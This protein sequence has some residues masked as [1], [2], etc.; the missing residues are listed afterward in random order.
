MRRGASDVSGSSDAAADLFS[1]AL[2][3]SYVD[4][5]PRFLERSWLAD[6]IEEQLADSACRFLLLTGEPGSGKT[7]LL[8]WLARSNPAWPRYFIRRD[9]QVPLNSGDARSLLFAL[10]HQLAALRPDLFHPD[11]LELVVSQRVGEVAR[12]GRAVGISVEDL[13]VSPFYET[14][15]R[16][17][18]QA[19]FVAGELAGIS[20]GRLV[21]EERLLQVTNLQYLAVVDPAELLLRDD[22]EGRLV[23]LIDALDELR[24]QPGEESALDWLAACPELS[25]NVRF[26]LTSRPDERLLEVF[27][28]RQSEWLREAAMAADPYKVEADLGRYATSF[29]GEANVAAALAANDIAPDRFIAEMVARAEGNFLYL[30]ALFRALERAVAAVEA[31]EPGQRAEQEQLHRLL[32]LEEVPAGLSELYAFFL[33]L[34]R[35]A[36]ASERVEVAGAVLGESTYLPAWEGLYQPVLGVLAVARE[37]LTGKQIRRFGAIESEERWLE[38]ALG[39]LGPFLDRADGGYELYHATFAEFLT[40]AE[41]QRTHPRDYLNAVEWHRK[42]AAQALATQGEDWLSSE[43]DY[44]L[45]HTPSHLLEALT[46]P[47]SESS[48]E[49]LRHALIDVLTSFDFVEAK[50]RRLGIGPV[51]VDLRAALEVLE[52]PP[53][54]LAVALAVLDREAHNL[55]GWD[56]SRDPAVFA[57]QLLVRSD[58]HSEVFLRAAR[59]RLEALRVPY[60]A[61]RWRVGGESPALM[62]TLTG[63]E[64]DVSDV[65]VAADGHTLASAGH[66]GTVRVWDAES[67]RQLQ[68]LSANGAPIFAVAFA[69]NEYVLAASRD[70]GVWVFDLRSGLVERVFRRPVAHG[71]EAPSARALAASANGCVVAGYED[72]AVLVWSLHA[73]RLECILGAHGRQVNGAAFVDEN[74][75]ITCSDDGTVRVWDLRSGRLERILGEKYRDENFAVIDFRG[76]GYEEFPIFVEAVAAGPEGRVA[77]GLNDGTIFVWNLTAGTTERVYLGPASPVNSVAFAGDGRVIS[78]SDDRMIRLWG[79]S[80]TEPDRTFR[81]HDVWVNALMT[82]RGGRILSGSTDGTLKLWDLQV[83]ASKPAATGHRDWVRCVTVAANDLVVSG[84][85]DGTLRVWELTSGKPVRTIDA[86]DDWVLAVAVSPEGRIISG[87]RDWTVRTWDLASGRLEHTLTGHEGWVYAVAA[88]PGGRVVSGS[89]DGTVRIWNTGAG[90]LERVLNGHAGQVWAVAATADGCVVSASEGDNIRIWDLNSGDLVD[91][92]EGHDGRVGDVALLPPGRFASAGWDGTVRVWNLA[93]RR[94]ERTLRGHR[95][96]VTR[97]VALPPDRLL[98]TG[99]DRTLRVWDLDSGRLAAHVVLENVPACL[100]LAPAS[101]GVLIGDRLGGLSCL[102]LVSGSAEP[103]NE[104]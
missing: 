88:A 96:A 9:S 36:V 4:D 6:L 54:R 1:Q 56:P 61:P 17:E 48:Q 64:G 80:A 69:L 38:G 23:I 59:S 87:S 15:L 66:D 40:A 2:V 7:A 67:G 89:A 24:Y 12:G 53:V 37:P 70:G 47:A 42:I 93:D 82:L 32:R 44:P 18:Q 103:Q 86:H 74:T 50:C 49:P 60:F 30:A 94:L 46:H 91:V 29:A 84:S 41:T 43:D 79:D 73:G 27:R 68:V 19:D 57:Q 83:T 90:R 99:D 101:R 13:E 10:G 14:A 8:A 77:W 71:D 76:Q 63:H 72:G 51:L 95:G 39:R 92:L 26:V 85:H 35:D 100:G 11:R 21:A 45:A 52:D 22:P 65:D 25:A 104:R 75:V 20:V 102:E 81:G 55:R 16:V 3:R 31:A 78:G 34:V 5:E 28:R 98:S 97:L 62:R 58:S 33:S